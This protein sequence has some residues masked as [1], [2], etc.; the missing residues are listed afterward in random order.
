MAGKI[1][2]SY[3][4]SETA[5]AARALFERLARRFPERVFIDLE[6]IDLGSVFTEAIDR[7]LEGCHAMLAVIGA[8]WLAEIKDREAHGDEDFVHLELARSLAR[9][10]PIVPVLV[11]GAPMPRARDLPDDLKAVT[12]RNALPLVADTFE[13]Q[14]GRLEREV[15]K[16]LT[17]AGDLPISADPFAS[18]KLQPDRVGSIHA[19]I[20]DG[21]SLK[22]EFDSSEARDQ[23]RAHRLHRLQELSN[24]VTPA[25][26]SGKPSQ[27]W[28]HAEGVDQF[29]RWAEFKVD[30]AVQRL[31][32]IE[33]GEF[34]MGSTEAERRRFSE[35]TSDDYK[36]WIENEKPRH[37]VRLTQGFWLAETACTQALW[38]AVTGDNPSKFTG[39]LQLPVEQVSWN[40][41]TRHFLPELNRRVPSLQMVLPTEAQWEFA[42]RAGTDTAYAYG[43]M[44][45]PEQVNFDCNYPPPGG[46]KGEFRDKTLPVKGLPANA[47]GLYQMHSNVWEW[48]ADGQRR[49]EAGTASAPVGPQDQGASK[50]VLRGGSWINGGRDCRSASRN[51]FEPDGRNDFIGFRLARGLADQ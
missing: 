45:T 10:I 9:G 18:M 8:T 41:I 12:R 2:I 1:F 44:I 20:G 49:Y 27:K 40:D 22:G 29:G 37:R 17:E 33:P 42:C 35:G 15:H 51:A 6:G 30:S 28:M 46:D 23:R 32:W 24:L 3:R 31:R 7:H 43:E 38:Q 25:E 47:W 26:G 4:R 48:C 5:W 14:M 50:R 21:A 13:A 16:I 39:D 11:D 34:W 36:K 19:A